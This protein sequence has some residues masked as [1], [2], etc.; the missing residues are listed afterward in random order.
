[1]NVLDQA[2]RLELRPARL[3]IPTA[4]RRVAIITE[5]QIW[6]GLE[7]HAVSLAETLNA[8]GLYTTIACIGPITFALYREMV[9]AS[10]PLFKVNAP[11]GMRRKNPYDW[12]RELK[13]VPADC[14][15]FEK[16]TLF[17]GSVALDLA[18]R[19]A[20]GPYLAIEQLEA[21]PLPA[22]SSRRHFAGLLPGVGL[23]WYRWRCR[24]F[25]RSL[26]PGRTICISEAVRNRLSEMYGFA[27]HKLRLIPHGVDLDAFRIDP[28]RRASARAEWGIPSGAFIFGTARRLVADKGLDVALN[29]FARV[30]KAAPSRETHFIVAGDGPDRSALEAQARTLDI[31]ERVHFIGFHPRPADIFPAFD[32][33]LLP[34]RIEALGVVALEAM[35]CGCDLIASAVGGIPE[36]I[37]SRDI[38][39]LVPAGDD[40][41]LAAAMLGS[42]ARSEG[43]RL[44]RQQR[45]RAHVVQKY[46]RRVQYVRIADLLDE[47]GRRDPGTVQP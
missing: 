41:A 26:A 46:D 4:E 32:S 8:A 20:F 3:N 23:W 11:K 25:I 43:A 40:E 6:G 18:L 21:P 17:T 33:F 31:A 35:A 39:T 15:I 27:P 10:V 19:M 9:G 36:L 45:A 47:V 22:R 42:L 12:F 44:E 30:Q 38:A 29:A 5:S 24:G 28:L 13:S 34:S 14:A 37:P 2:E 1:M 16:G 7:A